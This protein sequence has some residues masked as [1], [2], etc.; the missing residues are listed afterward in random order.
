[1]YNPADIPG[2][3]AAIRRPL[4]ALTV[5][6]ALSG[7]GGCARPPADG[8]PVLRTDIDLPAE[9]RIVAARVVR[10]ATLASLLRAHEVAEQEIVALIARAAA[11]FD[12][13]LV[14][15][16]QPYRLARTDSG[17]LRHFEYE[18]DQNRVLR[19]ARERGQP[20]EAFV[21]EIGEIPK[22]SSLVV[23]R[24]GIDEAAM[25]LF[26]AMDRAGERVELPLMLAGVFSGDVD[27]NTELQLGDRFQLLVEKR[28]R[29]GDTRHPEEGGDGFAGYGPIAAAEFENDGR[30]LRAV[31]FTP[32]GGT[33][34]YYDEDGT[35][36]RRFFLRSPL[37]FDP[38]ITSRFSRSRLHPVL[39]VHRAHLGVDYR[40]PTGAPVIAVADGTVVSAGMNGGAGRMVHLR[41]ANGFETQYLHLSTIAVRRGARVRQGELI[42]R[43]GST[44][45]ATAAHLDYR[46]R[47][48]G[49]FV[50]PVTAHRLMPP[51]D[52]VPA[53]QMPA[54]LQTRDRAF[55]TLLASTAGTL[56]D[57]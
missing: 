31:R 11:V 8:P 6:L 37:Q 54:F 51:G 29:T 45:L 2:M 18:I 4:A 24:G 12:L 41:H 22:T 28:Y 40:A 17:E 46:M 5:V 44:G 27:F 1:V 34:G 48:N 55:S 25:S 47:Q 30:R 16:D 36:L 19:V 43:V 9:I 13:R 14:R 15:A 32:E 57:D 39:G 38:V 52:P 33:P 53:D 26:A 3:T 42:G 20:P 10:G 23:V 35:S 21:A 56:A 7:S 50:N 49:V